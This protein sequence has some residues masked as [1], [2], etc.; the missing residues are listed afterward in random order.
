MH[1]SRLVADLVARAGAAVPSGVT[2]VESVTLQLLSGSHLDAV[3]LRSQWEM[4]AVG[5]PV[6]GA[7]VIIDRSTRASSKVSMATRWKGL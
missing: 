7:E 2:S 3:T 1:E 6:E 4:W 5:S